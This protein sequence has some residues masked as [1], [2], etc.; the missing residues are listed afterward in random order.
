MLA[1]GQENFM[2][3]IIEDCPKEQLNQKEQEYQQIFGAK[4][5]G[6]SIK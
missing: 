6:Y 1:I 3:E 2:F 4:E 5:F